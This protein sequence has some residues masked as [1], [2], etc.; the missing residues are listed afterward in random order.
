MGRKCKYVRLA[1]PCSYP[2]DPKPLNCNPPLR[3]LVMFF[4]NKNRIVLKQNRHLD[5][6]KKIETSNIIH[7]TTVLWY[8]TKRT[9]IHAE[10]N[11]K[12]KKQKTKHSIFNKWC[13]KTWVCTCKIKLDSNLSLCTKIKLNW[14]K[15]INVKPVT[16]RLTEEKKIGSIL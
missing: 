12:T 13:W 16:L 3:L 5:Q 1:N 6:G 4:A 10:K 14:T 7:I 9:K 8:L 15:D 2:S 11:K